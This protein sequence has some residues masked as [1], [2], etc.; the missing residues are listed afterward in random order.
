VACCVK[1]AGCRDGGSIRYDIDIGED[2]RGTVSPVSE[3]RD[4]PVERDVAWHHR[5][6]NEIN[7]AVECT[8]G[9]GD[10]SASDPRRVGSECVT[11]N[12]GPGEERDRG[13]G[14]AS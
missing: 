7:A 8:Y 1:H 14:S 13:E 10:R 11:A 2:K 3:A 6:R 12:A 9:D 4:L 5:V